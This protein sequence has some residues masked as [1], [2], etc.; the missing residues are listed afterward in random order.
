MFDFDD[1]TQHALL[2]LQNDTLDV[3]QPK[4]LKYK[5]R[6]NYRSG[7]DSLPP[8]S[9]YNEEFN[10]NVQQLVKISS[11]SLCLHYQKEF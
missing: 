1:I 5:S 11:I 4:F 7:I 3:A 2:L 8:N 10:K 6:E 9:K